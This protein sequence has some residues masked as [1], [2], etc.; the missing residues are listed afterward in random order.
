MLTVIGE[1]LVDVVRP[2]ADTPRT[3]PGGSPL[4]VAVGLARLGHPVRFIGRHGQDEHG[5]LVREH[6]EGAGVEIP[7]PADERPTP[8]AEATLRE[9]GAAEYDFT[10]DW[11]LDAVAD[12]LPQLLTAAEVLHVGSIGAMLDPGAQTVL[13]A[14]RTAAPHALISY[15]PNCRPTIVPDASE[16]RA[17]AEAVVEHA[18]VVKAS[19]EDLLWL[20]PHRTVEQTAAAWLEAGPGLVVVTRGA[21]GSWALTRAT[22]PDGVSVP[23]RTTEVADTV[24]AGDALMAGLLSALADRGVTGREAAERLGELDREDL[25]SILERAAAAAAITVSRPG[26]NPPTREE[27][28]AALDS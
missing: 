6:L 2:H 13:D 12:Q 4:N 18:D 21:L 7:V 11:N 10:L 23:A 16:A 20:Y 8:V 26:A 22:A 28:D 9:D 24:G 14:V 15:D 27:L 3:L 25:Q 5:Q 17:R 1:A 19:D